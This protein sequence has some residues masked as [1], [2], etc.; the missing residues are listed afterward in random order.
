MPAEI[1]GLLTTLEEHLVRIGV[2]QAMSTDYTIHGLNVYANTGD[3]PGDVVGAFLN[4]QMFAE[5]R[6]LG[7]HNP[8]YARAVLNNTIAVVSAY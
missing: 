5:D 6:S 2:K 4:W 7:L 8:P 3:W 1:E